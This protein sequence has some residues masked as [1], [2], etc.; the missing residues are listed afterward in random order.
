MLMV[1]AEPAE[2][3]NPERDRLF[4]QPPEV[5]SEMH[6]RRRRST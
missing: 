4:H 3:S 6:R 5:M 1:S 2:A